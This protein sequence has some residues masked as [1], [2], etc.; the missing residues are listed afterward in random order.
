MAD[1]DSLNEY[2]GACH[3]PPETAYKG[4]RHVS[5]YLKAE[6]V[7]SAVEKMAEKYLLHGMLADRIVRC[8]AQPREEEDELFCTSRFMGTRSIQTIRWW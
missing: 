8:F 2:L 5:I 6:L 1:D 4:A 7:Y 3:P